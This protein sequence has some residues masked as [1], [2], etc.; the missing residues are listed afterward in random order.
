MRA[1]APTVASFAT[2]ALARSSNSGLVA[3]YRGLRCSVDEGASAMRIT[4]SFMRYWSIVDFPGP[5][6][7][8]DEQW[9]GGGSLDVAS[10]GIEQ[11]ELFRR[12]REVGLGVLFDREP[13]FAIR[14]NELR[15]GADAS[16]AKIGGVCREAPQQRFSRGHVADCCGLEQD[17]AR[18]VR[19]ASIDNPNSDRGIPSQ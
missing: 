6:A 13:R 18:R 5:G 4:K 11:L 10:H 14:K 2:V 3:M 1:S 7:P 8:V 9:E 16:S 19:Q 12:Q 17:D 15:V